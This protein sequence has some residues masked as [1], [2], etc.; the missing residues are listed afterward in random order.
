MRRIFFSFGLRVVTLLL[1]QS[2]VEYRER[3]QEANPA[4][5]VAFTNAPNNPR[6]YRSLALSSHPVEILSVA[7]QSS[8]PKI[9]S[10][11]N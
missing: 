1:G 8:V 10:P 4:E 5:G 11:D 7:Y 3:K 6:T 9:A 2:A